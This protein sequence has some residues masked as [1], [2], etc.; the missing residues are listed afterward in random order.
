[1]STAIENAVQIGSTIINLIFDSE[2]DKL[3]G[4]VRCLRLEDRWS[5]MFETAS[6]GAVLSLYSTDSWRD[7]VSRIPGH[8]HCAPCLMLTFSSRA[9]QDFQLSVITVAFPPV[10][11]SVR[12]HFLDVCVDEAIQSKSDAVVLGGFFNGSMLWLENRVCKFE[13]DITISTNALLC[14]LPW[15]ARGSMKC[16]ALDSRGPHTLV[17]EHEQ[18]ITFFFRG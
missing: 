2:A 16:I 12:G 6:A 11:S 8:R 18:K 1:M 3:I 17:I 5:K 10:P 7:P 14:V 15:C 4:G 9:F 13:L